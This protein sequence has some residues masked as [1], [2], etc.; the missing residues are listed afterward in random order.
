MRLRPALAGC[1]L[2]ALGC[3]SLPSDDAVVYQAL[4]YRL[5]RPRLLAIAASPTALTEGRETTLEALV[6]GPGGAQ[7]SEATWKTCGLGLERPATFY[8]LACFSDDL[9]VSVI[10]SGLPA[11]WT[12]P[13]PPACPDTG[14]CYPIF[15]FLLEARLD[16]ETVRG[17]FFATVHGA[18]E[19]VDTAP[20]WRSLSLELSAAAAE[21]GVV[22]LEARLGLEAEAAT[23]RWYVDDGTLLDT[24][25]TSVQRAEEGAVISTNRWVLPE[26]EGPWRVV[27]VVSS[28]EAWSA[29]TGIAW[30]PD[31][32]GEADWLAW[33]EIPNMTWT[34]LEVEAP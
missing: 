28:L 23:F 4:D 3:L 34:I 15:P 14:G 22:A 2:A 13:A 5:D 30:L 20:S 7:A 26:G 8:D 29:D 1:A 19:V 32:P 27:V 33:S 24:G 9:D 17:A 12:P 31:G 18:D 11:S 16:G 6:L 21:D 10:A 25:R